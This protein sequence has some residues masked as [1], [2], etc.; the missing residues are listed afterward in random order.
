MTR[1]TDDTRPAAAAQTR[2]RR[3]TPLEALGG[4]V[5]PEALEALVTATGAATDAIDETMRSAGVTASRDLA[6]AYRAV[7]EDLVWA[8]ERLERDADD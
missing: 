8:A 6:R 4:L 3:T 2:R 5:T 7:A 1:I